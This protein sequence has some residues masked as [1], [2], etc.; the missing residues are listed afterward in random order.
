MMARFLELTDQQGRFLSGGFEHTIVALASSIC[1]GCLTSIVVEIK[2]KLMKAAL[3]SR[4]A[5]PAS[6][7]FA[8]GMVDCAPGW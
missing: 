3:W 4:Q 1:A 2:L 7:P 5:R 8:L 6:A